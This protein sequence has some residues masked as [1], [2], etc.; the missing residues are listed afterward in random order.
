MVKRERWLWWYRWKVVVA[1]VERKRIIE[2]VHFHEVD[3]KMANYSQGCFHLR[4]YE[5]EEDGSGVGG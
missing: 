4:Q 5:A 3:G 2:R 1:V